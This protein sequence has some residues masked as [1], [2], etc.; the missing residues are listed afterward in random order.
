[1]GNDHLRVPGARNL[2][3]VKLTWYEGARDGKRNLPPSELFPSGFQP[4]DS[5]SLFMGSKGK[6][7]SPSDYGS[8]QVLWPEAQYKDF[9]DPEPALPRIK[10]GHDEDE[11][12]KREW[13]E[14]IRGASR[15]LPCRTSST[16]QRLRNRCSWATSRFVRAR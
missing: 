1:M 3:P 12:Q 13:I 11:N 16:H 10:G 5:G 8:D 4:S 7:Y 14:A 2:P 6:M 15:T 9:K